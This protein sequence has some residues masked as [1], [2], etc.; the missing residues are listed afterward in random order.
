MA[1]GERRGPY[2]LEE[3]PEAGLRPASWVWTKGMDDW[4]QAKDVPEIRRFY[5]HRLPAPKV[6]P[7]PFEKRADT[8]DADPSRSLHRFA[9]HIGPDELPTLEDMEKSY[10]YTVRPSNTLPLAI[11]S[12]VVFP[13]M[14][15]FAVYFSIAARR[16][17]KK[18]GNPDKD[19]KEVIKIAGQKP[20]TDDWRRLAHE[21]SRWAK[22]WGG[23]A[24]FLGMIFYAFI[25]RQFL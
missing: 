3:L 12:T 16:C 19:E 22:M 14:G 20:T 10:D 18:S 21:Y 4:Q 17:W 9:R 5:L 7:A 24:F 6:L 25:I 11:L 8:V 23:I 13:P 1:D 2:L 15:I